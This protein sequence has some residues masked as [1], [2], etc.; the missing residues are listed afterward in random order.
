VKESMLILDHSA[1]AQ[2]ECR[3]SL[4]AILR[5]GSRRLQQY[6]EHFRQLKSE[7]GQSLVVRNGYHQERSWSV[8]PNQSDVYR[9][10]TSQISSVMSFKV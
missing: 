6:I 5:E 8:A 4:D 9:V 7:S 3:S 2:G 1:I 10:M